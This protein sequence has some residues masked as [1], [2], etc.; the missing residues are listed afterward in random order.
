MHGFLVD[1]SSKKPPKIM[2][3]TIPKS[4]K[5]SFGK[6]T[7]VLMDF[8]SIV[9]GIWAPKCHPNRIRKTLKIGAV[10]TR[11]Q[12]TGTQRDPRQRGRQKYLSDKTWD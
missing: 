1:F 4:I 12:I 7:Y 3:K 2:A 5:K 8:S 6:S 9:G 10:K 11:L